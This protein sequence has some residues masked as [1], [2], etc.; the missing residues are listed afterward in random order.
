[1][2]VRHLGVDVFNEAIDRLVAQYEQGHRLVLSFSGGKDSTCSLELCIIAATMTGRLP[3]DVVM[4]DE[5]IMFPGTY[6]YAERVAA[7]DEVN[8]HWIYARQPVINSFNREQPFFWVFDPLLPPEKWVRQPPSFAYEVK[9]QNI[10]AMNTPDRFPPDPGKDLISVIGLRVQE[11][12]GRRYGLHSSG[13]YMTGASKPY[14]IRN[15]RPIY[16]WTDGDVWRAIH[17]NGWDYNE[18]YNALYRHGVKTKS[19]RIGPPTMNVGGAPLLKIAQSVWPRWFDRVAERLPG[20]RT[21][22]Q[23]GLRAVTAQ[24]RMGETWRETYERECISNAP[25]WIAER[26]TS[27]RDKMLATHSR[28][29]TT[30]FPETDPCYTC[31][32]NLGS[33]RTMVQAMYLGDPFSMKATFMPYVEPEFFRPGAGYWNGTPSF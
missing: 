26:A 3:V 1:M 30:P 18:A 22:A 19:L 20:T 23:F 5:E 31:S 32:G 2:P 6:E 7:R 15:C 21:V 28:H 9:E 4:R 29:A 17:V 8:F 13:G 11:S 24:R 14:G 16:D 25:D 10:T 27:V 33:W 12:R